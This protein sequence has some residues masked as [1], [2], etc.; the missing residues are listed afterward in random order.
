MRL[1][2]VICCYICTLDIREKT[3][4]CGTRSRHSG[5]LTLWDFGNCIN[6]GCNLWDH[7]LGGRFQIISLITNPCNV[8]TIFCHI[9]HWWIL[10][11]VQRIENSRRRNTNTGIDQ[12]QPPIRSSRQ[13][14]HILTRALHKGQTLIHANR[15]IC[16][17]SHQFVHIRQWN[18]PILAECPHHCRRITRAATNPRCHW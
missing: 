10:F 12:Y 9:L 18:R 1:L 5:H 11:R 3:K 14:R 8:N 16:P 6:Y 4:A 15:N 13:L 17:Q 7:C 2:Q